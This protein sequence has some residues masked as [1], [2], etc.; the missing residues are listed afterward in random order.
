MRAALEL[1]GRLLRAAEEGRWNGGVIEI[2]VLQ[3]L[4]HQMRG[5]MPAALVPLARALQLA[6]PEGY[7][8][9]FLDEGSPMATLLEAAAKAA[10]PRPTFVVSWRPSVRR[11]P[12]THARQP[13]PGRAAQRT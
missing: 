9:V 5:D 12:E 2:L 8:R 11:A 4:A 1:L 13:D 10:S 7:V 6:E 3:A